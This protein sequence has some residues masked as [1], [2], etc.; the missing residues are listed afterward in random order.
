[1]TISFNKALGI[2][3]QA[4]AL[5]EKRS[6]MI[7][8][9]LANADTPNYK[10]RDLDFSAVFQKTMSSTMGLQQTQ[11]RH[12]SLSNELL[13]AHLKYR[14]PN[15]VSLDGNTVEEHLEQANYSQ[16]AVQYEASLQFLS[17]N[18]AG[19]MTAIKGQ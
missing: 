8:A 19:L 3:P 12:L 6:E 9:N 2:H 11:E 14:N 1:M 7:A 5:R 17:N 4:L 15:Q 10:A 13:G 18:F 16:N